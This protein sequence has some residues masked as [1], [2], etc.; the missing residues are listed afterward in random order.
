MSAD[1]AKAK[2]EMEESANLM[3]SLEAQM[4]HVDDLVEM[5]GMLTEYAAKK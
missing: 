1:F 5:E 2:K 4:Q 3:V